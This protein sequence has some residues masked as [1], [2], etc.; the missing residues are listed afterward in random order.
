MKIKLPKYIPRVV[1]FIDILGFEQLIR[2]FPKDPQRFE[3]L[4]Y[5]LHR[6]KFEETSKAFSWNK[7]SDLEISAFSDSIVISAEEKDI[8]SLVCSVG[9]LQAEL[10]FVGVITRGGIA[11]GPT[12]HQ[13]GILYGEGMLKAYRLEQHA[14]IYPRV[15]F[16]SEVVNQY[17]DSLKNW[18]DLDFDGLTFIDFFKF[19]AVAGNATEL[20]TEGYDPRVVYFQEVRE[21]LINRIENAAEEAHL[22]KNRWIANR[23]NIAI[24]SF[25]GASLE[26]VELI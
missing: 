8:S 13:D 12:I 11:I 7:N 25:N 5:V 20:A 9:W 16:A 10:L 21:H 26:K 15:V 22:A 19:D 3:Q 17:Q 24:R 23:F 2:A 4:H 14:A 18:I 1:A 6:I